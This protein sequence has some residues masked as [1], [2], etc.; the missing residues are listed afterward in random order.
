VAIASE[1][2]GSNGSIVRTVAWPSLAVTSI[3]ADGT[4]DSSAGVSVDDLGHVMWVRSEDAWEVLLDAEGFTGVLGRATA[5]VD[6]PVW[7]SAH[8]P[9][10]HLQDDGGGS[11]IGFDPDT[12]RARVVID[13]GDWPGDLRIDGSG[14]AAIVPLEPDPELGTL[15]IISADGTWTWWSTLP[16]GS[17]LVSFSDGLGLVLFTDPED[18]SL[19]ASSVDG[20]HST[21]VLDESAGIAD[22]GMA[23]GIPTV[24]YAGGEAADSICFAEIGSPTEWDMRGPAPDSSRSP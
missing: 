11:L 3:A 14:A 19:R 4:I 12:G 7:T 8:G 18:G 13:L 23:G 6:Q 9:I 16:E 10:A 15:G 2:R 1:V 17:R 20:A 5:P 24:A 22:V 21:V